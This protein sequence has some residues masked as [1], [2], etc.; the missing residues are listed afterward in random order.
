[1]SVTDRPSAAPADLVALDD[2]APG[3]A[4]AARAVAE[5][6]FRELLGS[7]ALCALI[8]DR[9]GTIELAN[10][11][12]AELLGWTPDDLVGRDWFDTCRSEAERP[13]ARAWLA[14]VIAG[15]P[16]IERRHE[17]NVVTRTGSVRT[18]RW[19]TTVLHGVDGD[20]ASVAS[21]GEDVTEAR[22]TETELARL[23]A[24]VA[25]ATDMI[26]ITGPDGT[27]QYVNR[28]FELESGYAAH[29]AVGRVLVDLVRSGAHPDEFYADLDALNDRAGAWA[30]TIV[31]RR[32][33]GTLHEINLRVSPF[34][35][36]SGEVAGYVHVGRDLTRERTL[37]AQ[38]RQAVKMEAIGQLAGGIAHDF[39]NMLTAIRGYAELVDAE[40][41]P[42]DV[43]V[44]DDLAQIILTADRAAALTRQLL[45]FARKQV[46]EPSVLD[47]AGVID[48]LAPML[49]RLLGEHVEL[50]LDARPAIG[51][52]L[53]DPHQL[54]QVLLNLAVNGR[55]AMPGGGTLTIGVAEVEV[56]AAD[57][58]AWPHLAPGPH[59][60]L[61]VADTGLG[62]TR[63]TLDRV[64]EPFFTTKAPGHGTGMGLAMVHGIVTGAGG[65]IMAESVPG[66]GATF[67]LRFPRRDAPGDPD[68]DSADGGAVPAGRGTVLLVEDE[69]T[70]RAFAARCLRDLGYLVV[71]AAG[72][73]AAVE[74]ADRPGF[75]A[76]LLVTDMAMPGMPG[77]EL[78]RTLAAVHPGL[79]VLFVSGY[80]DATLVGEGW[81]DGA[82]GF[83]AKP[84][85]RESLGRAVAEALASSRD[86]SG[87]GAASRRASRPAS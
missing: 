5:A 4:A 56:D 47:P 2:L 70:V 58:K 30:D 51:W 75:H 81:M 77:T 22:E 87:R 19:S 83:L 53:I 9:S 18:L 60:E 43:E 79:P 54:E 26:A 67:R 29:E 14:D 7:V 68:R 64:F 65:E 39:N 73:P 35:G 23:A 86:P 10:E 28:A 55:D 12:L 13:E 85:T 24:A 84:Y 27:I 71:D 33:D 17:N 25:Q 31:D 8:I 3:A 80:A 6:R 63:Q 20:V 57:R 48:G 38:L 36:P 76:D 21:L 72:G 16:V 50:V 74:L 37:E 82:S 62:M 40:I 69:P 41:P 44:R 49:R 1:M 32:R 46:A 52:I 78:A 11:H 59:V 66:G 45:A 15:R 34:R 61:V 42:R